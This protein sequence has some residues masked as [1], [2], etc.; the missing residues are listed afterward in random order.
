M[1][2]IYITCL[3]TYNIYIYIQGD[4]ITSLYVATYYKFFMWL[5]LLLRTRVFFVLLPD[6]LLLIYF[7][8]CL[9]FYTVDITTHDCVSKTKG[10]C[11]YCLGCCLLCGVHCW[12]LVQSLFSFPLQ[13]VGRLYMEME[14]AL[15]E[16]K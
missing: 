5:S 14:R 3:V 6:D 1:F 4:I 15:K 13:S 12:S 7:C 8:C 2:K 10:D 9:Y 16:E 11:Y